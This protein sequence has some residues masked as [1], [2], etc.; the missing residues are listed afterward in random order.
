[1]APAAAVAGGGGTGGG[2]GGGAAAHALHRRRPQGARRRGHR[3]RPAAADRRAQ[4]DAR[5]SRSPQLAAD[6]ADRRPRPARRGRG[7]RGRPVRRGATAGTR[8]P[9]SDV[10]SLADPVSPG[11]SR[12]AHDHDPGPG[13]LG[14][15]PAL[16]CGVAIAHRVRRRSPPTG[17]LRLE[18]TTNVL[19]ASC[20][21]APPRSRPRCCGARA[22][23][24]AP[25][26]RGAGR[27]LAFARAR[28]LHRALDAVVARAADSW[29]EAE[30]HARLSRRR[31]PAA[32]RS[33][34]SRPAAGARC[35]SGVALGCRRCSARWALLTKVFPA[36]LAPD[37]TYAR[38]REPF[39]YW[40]S[41]GLMAALGVP[42]MLWLAARRSGHAAVNALAW[43]GARRCCSSC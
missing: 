22:R 7:G 23:A 36:S 24:D 20:W 11:R 43:P 21:S 17:G 5:G 10:S 2:N 1:M 30:P 6:D 29:I 28:G 12:A 31:S 18:R 33:R 32:S 37:E 25:L 39:A 15:R 42:P 19:I 35:S 4:R 14:Q 16:A 40:N 9:L 26:V 3:R 8:S 41:V 34:G 13:R 27:S 38:L